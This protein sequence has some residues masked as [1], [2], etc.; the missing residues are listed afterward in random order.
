VA[1]GSNGTNRIT[2][3]YQ[4]PD[5][6]LPVTGSTTTTGSMPTRLS[7]GDFNGDG[8]ADLVYLEDNTGMKLRYGQANNTFSGFTA[9][10]PPFGP[11]SWG[12]TAVG[13]LNRD[14]RLDAV[15]AISTSTTGMGYAGIAYAQPGGTYNN[16]V[17]ATNSNPSGIAQ[18]DLN[19][20]Q[21]P[22]IIVGDNF[23]GGLKVGY[24][25]ASGTFTLKSFTYGDRGYSIVARDFNGD[26]IP[27]IAVAAWNHNGVGIL[28]T[29]PNGDL[30]PPTFFAASDTPDSIAA[31]DFNGD[32]VADLVL[33]SQNGNMVSVLLGNGNGSF[34][35]RRDLFASANGSST[36]SVADLDGNG[37]DDIAVAFASGEN[38]DIFYNT[39]P[40]PTAMTSLALVAGVMTLRRRCRQ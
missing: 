3:F 40:E 18:A 12:K 14:G 26:R 19:G 15:I 23:S 32:G 36:V 20:D 38:L 33:G 31:G 10:G 1:V 22:D 11:A 6:T 24:G 17:F 28:L 37:G 2:T 21:Y 4:Q 8:R 5:R 29:Q 35:S 9:L 7:A 16:A 25:S 30:G 13:D 39:I 34:G 27:D